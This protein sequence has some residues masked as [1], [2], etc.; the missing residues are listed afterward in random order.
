MGFGL[1]IVAL[2]FRLVNLQV[3]RHGD[4]AHRAKS[5]TEMTIDVLPRRGEI[6]DR[7]GRKLAANTLAESLFAVPSEI[8]DAQATAKVLARELGK[9]A[10]ELLRRL[11]QEDRDFVWIERRA[12]SR[13]AQRIRALKLPGVRVR[14]ESARHYPQGALAASILGFVDIDNRGLAGLEIQYDDEIRGQAARMTRF[15]DAARRAYSADVSLTDR[16]SLDGAVEGASLTLTLDAAIQHVVER[17]LEEAVK[18]AHAS[19]GSV[20]V[21]EPT[22]GAILAMAT[23]PTFDPNRFGE[24][25]KER[26]RCRPVTDVFE[27]GS[28]FKVVAA[29]SALEAGLVTLDE[30]IDCG[31]GVLAIGGDTIHEHGGHRWAR[32]SLG[33]ILAHS[34]NI[35]IAHVALKL[36]Q[37]PFFQAVKRFG[38]GRRTGIDLPGETRGLL[39]DSQQWTAR[40]LPT[41]SFGQEIGVTLVQIARAYSAIANGGVLPT[42]HL[43]SEIHRAGD[44]PEVHRVRVEPGVQ[45][46]SKGTAETVRRLLVSVTEAGTGKLGA[47]AG[48]TVAG[49]TGTAQKSSRGGYNGHIA[50]FVGM[51]PA[52]A[53]RLVI[54]VALDEPRS[55]KFHGGDIA[56]PAF[57]AIGAEA[58][59]LVGEPANPLPSRVTPPILTIDLADGGHGGSPDPRLVPVARH[60]ASLDPSLPSRLDTVDPELGVRGVPDVLGLPA[61]DAVRELIA[62]GYAPHLSGNGFVVAQEPR[63]G[64]AAAPESTVRLKLAYE[65]P[66][67]RAVATVLKAGD[68]TGS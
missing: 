29:A 45:I 13:A 53:P 48:Y 31:N 67:E 63:A 11:K 46:I 15:R 10:G 19:G 52:E 49:K 6:L 61:R 7:K 40:S 8:V 56:A 65:A 18:G 37:D 26:H 58:L 27:P 68:R 47:I 4:F 60:L 44:T 14:E 32:L 64:A 34:S 5:Q 51:V 66:G 50:S 21:M 33:E 25:P 59:R 39:A 43:V 2:V 24:V 20:V 62:A 22:S 16:I 1:W 41:I 42:P 17:E 9:D 36:G 28:T 35:G 3:V 55:A 23:S 54:A 57:A 30:L 12:D 38:F